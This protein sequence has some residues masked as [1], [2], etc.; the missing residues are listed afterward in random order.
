MPRRGPFRPKRATDLRERIA[1]GPMWDTGGPDGFTRDQVDEIT[2]R[3]RGWAET[4]VL[5]ELDALV[6]ELRKK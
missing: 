5:P 1:R 4:W 2:N 6:P 3:Y